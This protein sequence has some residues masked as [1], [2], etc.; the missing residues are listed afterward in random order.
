MKDEG[1][2]HFHPL[3]FIPA[4]LVFEYGVCHRLYWRVDRAV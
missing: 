1:A 4:I 3:F 2:V